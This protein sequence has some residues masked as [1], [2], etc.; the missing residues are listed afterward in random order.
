LNTLIKKISRE[1]QR[2]GA[3][4]VLTTEKDYFK[5]KDLQKEQN[6]PVFYNRIELEID[7]EFY[8]E[9]HLLLKIG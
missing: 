8:P 2:I 3:E 4:A 1:I 6:I 9:I 7:K 5:L